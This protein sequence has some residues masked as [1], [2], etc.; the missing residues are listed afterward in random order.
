M[1]CKGPGSRGEEGKHRA[2]MDPLQSAMLMAMSAGK[3]LTPHRER[4][5]GECENE[6]PFTVKGINC[7]RWEGVVSL[8]C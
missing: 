5:G 2:F 7:G 1:L 4:P 3:A 6:Q 8:L